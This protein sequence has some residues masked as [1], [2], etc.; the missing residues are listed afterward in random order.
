VD[1]NQ[2][3]SNDTPH[4][5]HAAILPVF[6]RHITGEASAAD[7]AALAQWVAEKP[8]RQRILDTLRAQWGAVPNLHDTDTAWARMAPR[9]GEAGPGERPSLLGQGSRRA[10]PRFASHLAPRRHS[11]LWGVVAASAA[12]IIAAVTL[13]GRWSPEPPASAAPRVYAT[14]PG[15]R[16]EL[17]LPDGTRV[18]VAPDSR[19]RIAADFGTQRRDVYV[20]GEAYFEVVHDTARPFTV[21]AANASMRDIGTAFAVR[22]YSDDRAVRVVVRDGQVAMSGAGLLAAGDVGRLTSEG[23]TSVRHHANLQVLLG[24]VH[25]Q[26]AFEDAPLAQ[27]LHDLGRWY[28]VRAELADSSLAQ[29]PFTGSLSD[30]APSGAIDLVAATLGLHVRHAGTRLLLEKTSASPEATR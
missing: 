9:I 12:A 23:R 29:L 2:H 17:H 1:K 7:E 19:L 8:G 25:G 3:D 14:G 22:S 26:L 4:D 6:E 21:F 13:H 5:A 18:T 16:A 30:I 10:A 28:G 24:W 27:V 20:E 15:Q 11:A